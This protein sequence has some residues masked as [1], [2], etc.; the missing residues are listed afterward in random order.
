MNVKVLSLLSKSKRMLQ[1]F[2][3]YVNF[4]VGLNIHRSGGFMSIKKGKTQAF[5]NVPVRNRH[6]RVKVDQSKGRS[7]ESKRFLVLQEKG[8]FPG[9][10]SD[11]SY[12][13]KG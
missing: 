9:S 4:V 13:T 11:S 8:S 3:E 6:C 2:A 7:A 12:N 5:R 10:S 1:F